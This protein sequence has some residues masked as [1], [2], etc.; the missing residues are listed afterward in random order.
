MK[1]MELRLHL[2]NFKYQTH[3]SNTLV[4]VALSVSTCHCCTCTLTLAVAFTFHLCLDCA[5]PCLALISLMLP[6]L[7]LH[8]HTLAAPDLPVLCF[9]A[10]LCLTCACTVLCFTSLSYTLP[11]SSLSCLNY[12]TFTSTVFSPCCDALQCTWQL[13]LSLRIPLHG[14]V[15][16]ALPCF[17]L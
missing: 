5:L 17:V 12:I 2:T 15:Y 3:A 4:V 14:Y 11:Y 16:C 10:A 6:H 8:C 1:N 9:T 7:T 13:P